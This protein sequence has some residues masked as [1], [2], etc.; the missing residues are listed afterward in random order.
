MA[1]TDECPPLEQARVKHCEM[2]CCARVGDCRCLCSGCEKAVASGEIQAPKLEPE[3]TKM[4]KGGWKKQR[5][6]S[7]RAYNEVLAQ[8]RRAIHERIPTAG[9]H[10]F[11]GDNGGALRRGLLNHDKN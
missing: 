3:K 6:A 8:K 7:K 9:Q 11:G 2:P 5:D 1:K 4:V 10:E